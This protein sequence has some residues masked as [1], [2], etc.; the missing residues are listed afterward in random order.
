MGSLAVTNLKHKKIFCLVCRKFLDYEWSLRTLN[1]RFWH[2]EI[3]LI[4]KD[5]RIDPVFEA[6]HAEVDGPGKNTED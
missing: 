1:R 5:T 6:V 3:F 2:I 4:N